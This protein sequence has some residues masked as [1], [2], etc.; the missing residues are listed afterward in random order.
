[1]FNDG[2]NVKLLAYQI[3]SRGLR[4]GWQ[5]GKDINCMCVI[6]SVIKKATYFVV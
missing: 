2:K 4:Q 5:D 3:C 6:V 1:M